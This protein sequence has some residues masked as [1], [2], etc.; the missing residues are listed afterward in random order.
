MSSRL[1]SNL[2]QVWLFVIWLY[3][4]RIGNITTSRR[5]NLPWQ[6]GKLCRR[7]PPRRYIL[8]LSGYQEAKFVYETLSNAIKYTEISYRE[9]LQIGFFT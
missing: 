1:S 4:A 6:C 2:V 5:L 8:I 7:Y 9:R 3:K